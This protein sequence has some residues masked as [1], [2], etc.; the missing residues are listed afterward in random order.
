MDANIANIQHFSVGDGDGIRTTL[1]FKGCNLRCPWCHNPET[2]SAAPVTLA[3]PHG[4]QDCGRRIPEAEILAELMED[5]DFYR[6]SGGGVTFSGG[7]VLLQAQAAQSLAARLK[8]AGISLFV[9]TAGCAPFS[10]IEALLPYADTWLFDYK[11]ASPQKFREVIGGDLALV[12]EN[13][14]RLLAR[15]AKVRI[16]IPL[17]PGFNT[18]AEDVALIC[19]RLKE[20]G[21]T[22]VDLLPFHRLGSGKYEALGLVYAYRDTPPQMPEEKARLRALYETHFTVTMES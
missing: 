8:A 19:S 5:A 9:D 6:E 14:Q 18:H 4:A 17:I 22:E 10:A 11:T 3:Y 21:I 12:E 2:L 1:F 16:R 13:L 7:E 20:F 15:G